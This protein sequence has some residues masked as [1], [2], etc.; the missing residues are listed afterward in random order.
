MGGGL[1]GFFEQAKPENKEQPQN[2]V[3]PQQPQYGVPP[4]QPQYGVSPQQPQYSA[5]QQS[6]YS[7]GMGMGGKKKSKR[8]MR[9][10]FKD[11]TPTTGLAYHASPFSGSTA[12]PRNM[13]GGK[14]RRRRKSRRCKSRRSRR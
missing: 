1:F 7:M 14:T 9:G 8:R 11:N 5:P 4:Q 12:Q 3:P 2:G 10:G 6:S 13:V